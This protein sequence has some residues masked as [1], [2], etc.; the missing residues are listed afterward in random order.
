MC[1][2]AHSKFL[3]KKREFR[4]GELLFDEYSTYFEYLI[5]ERKDV[6]CFLKIKGANSAAE[7][8][9][10]LKSLAFIEAVYS[11]D[12]KALKSYKNLIFE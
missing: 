8:M 2:K 6:D 10:T 11:V 12:K 7:W 9:N 5:P 4:Q 1:H 3:Q